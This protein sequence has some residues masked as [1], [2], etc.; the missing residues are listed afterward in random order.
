VDAVWCVEFLEH[1]GRNFHHNYLS[2]FRRAAL[3]FVTNS[4]WGGWHH[5]EVHDDIWWIS[6]FQSYGFVYSP[7]LTAMVRDVAVQE[8][9]NITVTGEKANPQHIWLTMKVKSRLWNDCHPAMYPL[10]AF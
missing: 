4:M 2:A 1:V 6:K 5:V 8:V 3:V 10:L 7:E 9:G